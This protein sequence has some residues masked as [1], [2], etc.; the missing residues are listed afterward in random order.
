VTVAVWE[1]EPQELDRSAARAGA[2]SARAVR[3]QPQRAN[4]GTRDPAWR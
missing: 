3:N 2:A 1:E 4:L